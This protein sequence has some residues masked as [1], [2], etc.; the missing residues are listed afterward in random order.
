MITNR[1]TILFFAKEIALG[2]DFLNGQNISCTRLE[3]RIA[4]E[5]R[6]LLDSP[7]C[8]KNIINTNE[9]ES[10]HL[11]P[12]RVRQKAAQTSPISILSSLITEAHTVVSTIRAK[13]D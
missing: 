7:H 12:L 11:Q 4:T 1:R 10:L 6:V 8:G 5:R 2:C 3:C 9:S 13:T